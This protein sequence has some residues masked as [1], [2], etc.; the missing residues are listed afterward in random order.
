MGM[1]KFTIVRWLLACA[2]AFAQ[3]EFPSE[4]EIGRAYRSRA[5]A[6]GVGPVR[7]PTGRAKDVRGWALK[8]KQV[9]R[10]NGPI[11][12]TSRHLVTARKDQTCAAYLIIDTLPLT[13]ATIK[14]ALTVER[15]GVRA[16]R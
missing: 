13:H 6:G 5:E 16:C 12:A 4:A 1:Y 7:I 3:T 11:V 9:S 15:Q 8:F 14:P 10:S 2:P